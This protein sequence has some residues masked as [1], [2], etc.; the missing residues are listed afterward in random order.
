MD[1]PGLESLVGAYGTLAKDP[2]GNYYVDTSNSGDY[3]LIYGSAYELTS[4]ERV[5]LSSYWTAAQSPVD[6]HLYDASMR[7]VGALYDD[8]GN[9]SGKETEIPLSFYSGSVSHPEVII[10]GHPDGD[11]Q[12]EVLGTMSG[13]YDLEMA[14][15]K[16]DG[17]SIGQTYLSEN[18]PTEPGKSDLLLINAN[19]MSGD[20]FVRHLQLVSLDIKPGNDVNSINPRNNGAIPVALLSY[21]G[22]NAAT[23]DPLTVR[24]GLDGAAEAHG[25]GHIEDVDGDGDLD[26]MLHFRTQETGI[27]CGDTSV[28]LDGQTFNGMLITGSDSINTVGCNSED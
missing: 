16:T 4:E 2:G 9:T 7:H 28:T 17:Y 11:Y 24:F 26:L 20:L 22:F 14:V 15:V 21:E 1:V 13:E 25:W 18:V 5:D 6:L 23:V 27:Q 12:L 10:I 3:R 8:Q 19:P